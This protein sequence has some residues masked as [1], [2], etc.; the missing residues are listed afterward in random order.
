VEQARTSQSHPLHV[1]FLEP[2][3]TGLPGRIGLTFA[4]GR[5]DEGATATWDRDLDTDLARLR[6]HFRASTL[7]CLLPAQEL[8]RLQIGELV[9]RARAAGLEVLRLP[10]S[11]FSAPGSDDEFTHLVVA[12]LERVRAGKT[13]VIHCRA[14]LGRTGMTAAA[15]LAAL[16]SG[17]QEAIAAVRRV[18]PG[19]VETEE[20]ESYV[21]RFAARARGG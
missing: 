3:V 6:D 11:D 19:A 5:K 9:G 18:R 1:D 4:P 10:I 7:V 13:V 21:A 12:V 2:D 14:G 20:Q 15:C 16:G 17:P 8:V